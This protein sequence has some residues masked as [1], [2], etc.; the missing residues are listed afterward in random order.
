MIAAVDG[1]LQPVQ[2]LLPHI[3]VLLPSLRRCPLLE[4][5]SPL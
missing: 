1:S 2:Q 3:K 4:H 5:G